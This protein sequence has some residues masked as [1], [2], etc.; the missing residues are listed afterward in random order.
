[1]HHLHRAAALDI[2]SVAGRRRWMNSVALVVA[3]GLAA[4]VVSAPASAAEAPAKAGSV[5]DLGDVVVT[6][7]RVEERIQD[8]PVAVTALS[9][10]KLDTLVVNNQA[11]LAKLAPGLQI[12]SCTSGSATGGAACQ[13]NIRGFTA[14]RGNQSGS[15][16]IYFADAADMWTSDYDL[17]S[18]QVLKGPQGTLFGDTTTGGAVLS[19]P[20]K[21]SGLQNA[22]FVSVEGGNF[23]YHQITAAYENTLADG[24]INFRLSGQYRRRAGYGTVHYSFGGTDKVGDVNQLYLRGSLVVKPIDK[25]ENYTVVIWQK[26]KT[27]GGLQPI[28][29]TDPRF[30]SAA[31]RN[32]IPSASPSA[33]ANYEYFTGSL[34]PAG[35]S[36]SQIAQADLA[37]QTAA[38]P[39]DVYSNIDAH[40]L[41]VYA[42]IV[43]QTK[44]T[45]NEHFYIRNIYQLRWIPKGVGGSQNYDGSVGPFL[46]NQGFKTVVQ[47]TPIWRNN[48]AN[49]DN[50]W[51][52]RQWTDEIQA[53]GDLFDGRL[54]LQGGYYHRTDRPGDFGGLFPYRYPSPLVNQQV[55][56]EGLPQ[57]QLSAAACAAVGVQ[58]AGT[59]CFKLTTYQRKAD[60]FYIQGTFKVTDKLNVTLGGRESIIGPAV[61]KSGYFAQPIV[62]YTASNGTTVVETVPV[63]NPTQLATTIGTP[64]SAQPGYHSF[65]Y[66]AT[67][68]YKFDE[69]TLVYVTTRKGF[70]PGGSNFNVPTTDPKFAFGPESLK[71][72]EV[73]LKRDWTFG[74]WRARTNV[75]VYRDWYDNIQLTTRQPPSITVIANAG[76]AD[77]HGAEFEGFISPNSWFTL[78]AQFDWQ[79]NKYTQFQEQTFCS[80]QFWRQVPGGSCDGLPATTPILIDHAAGTLTIAPAVGP[81]KS[82]TFKPDKFNPSITWSLRPE[83]HLDQVLGE[84]VVLGMNIYHSSGTGGGTG[85]GAS[86]LAG[87][88]LITVN[89]VFG[90]V[91]NLTAY[92]FPKYTLYDFSA[93]W[94]SIHGSSLS[95]YVRVTNLANKRFRLG[96]FA[97]YVSGGTAAPSPNEPRMAL[98]GVK[99]DF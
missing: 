24:K 66:S 69:D 33:T 76:T 17:Q 25:L 27:N 14:N 63:F 10:A 46:E 41:R 84:N 29:F 56:T 37:R 52:N 31:T 71:D 90:P 78:N 45:F 30:F 80:V 83:V 93:D 21:P 85:Q 55:A 44:W 61:T 96:D 3:S 91:S 39:D 51:N 49:I 36:Y 58:P 35:L 22:G 40:S 82:Y 4:I 32:V 65:T 8:V 97:T 59:P 62:N 5:T 42:G 38:G 79:S 70:K 28:S 48:W 19:T 73:G 47:N 67:A 81:A 18:I 68:D 13:V 64:D 43:N 53:V 92:S 94:H 15:I 2:V 95:A 16:A 88:P 7:R 60:A 9:Q 89:S 98:V 11:D 20:K 87:V 99:Y 86:N 34:P 72:V 23:N 50:G 1:M 75:S 6:A 12:T 74:G 54:Q 26:D 77:F 57:G